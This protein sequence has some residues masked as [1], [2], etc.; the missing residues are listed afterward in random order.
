MCLVLLLYY[1]HLRVPTVTYKT[2]PSRYPGDWGNNNVGK[3]YFPLSA[4]R[5]LENGMLYTPGL[6][7]FNFPFFPVW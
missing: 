7:L 3:A 5:V 1:Y 2:C 6:S 4:F